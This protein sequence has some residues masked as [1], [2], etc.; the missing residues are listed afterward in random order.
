M[1]RVTAVKRTSVLQT[2]SDRAWYRMGNYPLQKF[3]EFSKRKYFRIRR[4]PSKL[5]KRLRVAL[6]ASNRSQRLGVRYRIVRK[7]RER[8]R[9]RRN[10]IKF[11]GLKTAFTKKLRTR[12]LRYKGILGR[13]NGWNW[14]R[15]YVPYYGRSHILRWK[16]VPQRAP[17]I[18]RFEFRLYKHSFIL[19]HLPLRRVIFKISEGP[20]TKVRPYRRSSLRPRLKRN[21][22]YYVTMARIWNKYLR[23]HLPIRRSKFYRMAYFKRAS[24]LENL[25]SQ[26][27]L[28]FTLFKS[29]FFDLFRLT[30]KGEL[31]EDFSDMRFYFTFKTKRFYIN[32]STNDGSSC[33]AISPGMFIKFLNRRK[34]YKKNRVLCLVMAQY[35]RKILVLIKLKH[36]DV[37]I[38]RSPYLLNEIFAGIFRPL[39]HKFKDPTTGRV[40]NENKQVEFYFYIRFLIFEHNKPY[41]YM[42][43]KLKGRLKRKV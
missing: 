10:V 5:V 22:F 13:I 41:G 1:K 29:T 14:P 20:K 37:V 2:H 18:Q 31:Y 33:L 28:Y 27:N 38:R 34:S 40:I 26:I 15:N 30:K 4:K 21:A 17:H 42:K 16:M 23:L 12:T 3:R 36:F 32:L 8:V 9:R 11:L 43:K 6:R 35:I 19:T 25:S 24:L 39:V 7:S